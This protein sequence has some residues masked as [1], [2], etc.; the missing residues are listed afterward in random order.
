[1][2]VTAYLHLHTSKYIQ[3]QMYPSTNYVQYAQSQPNVN[4]QSE[5]SGIP[6]NTPI[7]MNHSHSQP[8]A[9]QPTYPPQAAPYASQPQSSIPVPKPAHL[10]PAK[11]QWQTV[12][13]KRCRK[14]EGQENPNEDKQDY[15]LG[16]TIP[17]ANRFSTLA[18]E[19]MEEAA[20]QSTEPKPPPIFIA[21]VTN[22]KP[23]MALLN[24]I[25]KD[26]YLVKTLYKDQVRVQPTE[27]SVYTTIVKALIDKNTEF[28]TY[29]PRQ[30]RSFRV[31]LKNI[32]PSTDLN[33]IK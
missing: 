22:I 11:Q 30:Y 21:G 14:T 1:M 29:K 20:K 18:E 31:V 13:R 7:P 32:H 3:T 12:S 2:R 26:K 24:T 23:L 6:Y 28:H 16:G 27:S 17:T 9:P 10:Q 19:H 25:A 8:I 4:I 15:W 5:S 33:D